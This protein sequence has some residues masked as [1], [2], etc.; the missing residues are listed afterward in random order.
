MKNLN[1][2]RYADK[3]H[4]NAQHKKYQIQII[5]KEVEGQIDEVDEGIL[6]EY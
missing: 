5:N 2:R 6:V 4:G 1:E 3:D